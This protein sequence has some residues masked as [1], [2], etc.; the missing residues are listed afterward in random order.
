M[1]PLSLL[2]G[3]P[4]MLSL[5]AANS[6]S[7]KKSANKISDKSKKVDKKLKEKEIYDNFIKSTDKNMNSAA[8]KSSANNDKSS[9]NLSSEKKKTTDNKSDLN[10]NVDP[11]RKPDLKTNK[12]KDKIS[13]DNKINKKSKDDSMKPKEDDQKVL[14]KKNKEIN[15]DKKVKDKENRILQQSFNEKKVKADLE[16]LEPKN[17][18]N[19]KLKSEDLKTLAEMLISISNK[20]KNNIKE[21]EASD[22]IPGNDKYFNNINQEIYSLKKIG[23]NLLLILSSIMPSDPTFVPHENQPVPDE[24]AFTPNEHPS[25]PNEL[26]SM[27]NEYSSKPYEFSSMLNEPP[28]LKKSYEDDDDDD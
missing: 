8:D 17:I 11:H 14:D 26:P 12:T 5:I 15:K 27:L 10:Q 21:I 7:K 1:S 9:N 28:V 4:L 23:N 18:Y 3:N 24:P 16:D 22:I 13:I 19:I 2:G 6:I 20:I 25:E